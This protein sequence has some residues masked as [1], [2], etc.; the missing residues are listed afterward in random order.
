MQYF[1]HKIKLN[2]RKKPVP[3][4][5]DTKF[6]SHKQEWKWRNDA[7]TIKKKRTKIILP[8]ILT[9]SLLVVC[10]LR[11]VRRHLTRVQLSVRPED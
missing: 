7:M 6:V 9:V 2:I 11:D 4:F 3:N 8:S 1:H 10:Y 5:Q